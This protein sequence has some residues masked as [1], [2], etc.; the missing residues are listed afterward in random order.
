M[1]WV[2]SDALVIF[3]TGSEDREKIFNEL[4][5]HQSIR[6]SRDLRSLFVLT[7][8][9]YQMAALLPRI[10]DRWFALLTVR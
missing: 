4:R 2:N 7:L 1:Y 3:W 8:P 6:V 5:P 9:N 10:F